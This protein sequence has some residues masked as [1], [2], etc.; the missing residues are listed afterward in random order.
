MWLAVEFTADKKTKPPFADDTVKAVVRRM[1]EL[2]V[3]SSAIG[4]AL[5]MA[6]PLIAEREQLDRRQRSPRRRSLT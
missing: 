6:P 4:N 3:L 1:K 2:G 5:E